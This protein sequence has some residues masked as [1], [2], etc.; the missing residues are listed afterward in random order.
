MDRGRWRR[1]VIEKTNRQTP[2]GTERNTSYPQGLPYACNFSLTSSFQI[3]EQLCLENS[4]YRSNDMREPARASRDEISRVDQL[5]QGLI[6]LQ[7]S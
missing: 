3:L 5:E 6:F 1:V 2:H 4:D 7:D